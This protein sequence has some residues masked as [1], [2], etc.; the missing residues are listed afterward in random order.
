MAWGW[1]GKT[2]LIHR[3]GFGL[4]ALVTG[5]ILAL[6][7]AAPDP[8]VRIENASIDSLFWLRG[9]RPVGQEIVLV[10]VDERSLKEVGRWPWAR[11][12]QA[13]LVKTIAADGPR[14]IGLDI[15]YA[16]AAES[17]Y[18]QSLRQLEKDISAASRFCLS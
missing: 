2:W 4:S 14:V 5:I 9:Q 15:I 12:K 7:W 8:L 17:Q 13:Q 16:E 11:D 1:L 10:A 3:L 18:L 6:V